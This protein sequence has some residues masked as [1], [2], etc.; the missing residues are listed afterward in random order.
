MKL[1]YIVTLQSR[2]H[3][4]LTLGSARAVCVATTSISRV[5]TVLLIL[6]LVLRVTATTD[7]L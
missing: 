2:E 7:P 1:T 5:L 4:V 3:A 6:L